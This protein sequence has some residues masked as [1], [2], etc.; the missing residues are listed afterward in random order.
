MERFRMRKATIDIIGVLCLFT[1]KR[2]FNFRTVVILGDTPATAEL[3][4]HFLNNRW[5]GY[6]LL[7]VFS[8]EG[9]GWKR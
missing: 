3:R 8:A 9:A 7:G 5:H 4:E 2:G 6:R 1:R